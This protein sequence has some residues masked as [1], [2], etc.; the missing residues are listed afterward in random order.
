MAT[1]DEFEVTRNDV[2]FADNDGCVFAELKSVEQILKNA[3]EIWT[4]ERAQA[5]KIKAG[6]TLREQL[7]FTDYL[8]KRQSNPSYSFRQHLREI[9]GAI[10]E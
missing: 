5:D 2:V 10:E 1:F 3:R 6:H 7:R 4:T 9:G 8:K